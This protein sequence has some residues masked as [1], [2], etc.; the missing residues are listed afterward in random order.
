[1]THQFAQSLL[2]EIKKPANLEKLKTLALNQL[3]TFAGQTHDDTSARSALQQILTQYGAPSVEDFNE[4]AGTLLGS[5]QAKIRRNTILTMGAPFLF[6][7]VV[8]GIRK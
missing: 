1:E 7:V 3:D 2:D 4:K 8:W 6:L 5:L